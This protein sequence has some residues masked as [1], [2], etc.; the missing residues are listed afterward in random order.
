[1]Y[2]SIVRVPTTTFVLVCCLATVSIQAHLQ[3][4]ALGP[5]ATSVST[6]SDT[7]N[8]VRVTAVVTDRRG[9]PLAGLKA[10]DFELLVDGK[11]QTLDSVELNKAVTSTTRTFAFLL[12]EFHTAAED[13]GAV[14][15]G[16]LRFVEYSLRSGDLAVVVKP[17][18]T[19][20]TIAITADRDAVRRAISTFEGRKGDFTP[21]T[22][23]E[24]NY[25][26]QAPDAVASAR[27]QIVTSAL[28]AIGMM[29]SEKKTA[30]SA[31]V[32]VSDGFG[33]QRSSREVPANLL[34]AIRVANRA[35]AA[36]YAFAPSLTPPASDGTTAQIDPAFADLTAL[37]TQTGGELIT[38]RGGLDTGL[39]RINRDL[40]AHYVLA[41]RPLH[42]NDGRFHTVQVGI[43]RQGALV[44]ARSGYVAPASP[45]MR[46][47]VTPV[48]SAPLRVLRRSPLIQS[49]SGVAPGAPGRANVMVTWE[50][51]NS[52]AGAPPRS[53]PASIV[54]SASTLDG[55]MLFDAAV[56]AVGTASAP[57]LPDHASFEAPMGPVRIDMKIL[58]EKGVVIDTDSRDLM[59]PAPN[60]TG[61]TI[62]SPAILRTRSAREF[63]QDASDPD[64]PAVPTREFR[65]TERLIVRVPA[66]DASGQPIGVTA[67][68]LNRIREPMRTLPAMDTAPPG[69][70]Q[71]DLQLASLAPGDYSVRFT[72]TGPTG[73]LA[74]YVTFK[75]I[76]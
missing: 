37:T 48:S 66:I 41:Y 57:D 27:A 11:Q 55:T 56:A 38:G 21:R 5:T 26:A 75:V 71:F 35:D 25:M 40:D 22:A 49:W 54:V 1:V 46:A 58:D 59:V 13:S 23:F 62:Y 28:R 73:V 34:T 53:R 15:E 60:K 64:A 17:L 45:E 3:M 16:L 72:A 76:G 18:D 42:G 69:F 50:P 44:R 63:R 24:R 12:D 6:T 74:E 2:T 7:D 36:V 67:V 20:T 68:L 65:R 70:T 10:A 9:Q 30:L 52:R 32:L 4:Q 43:K 31:I 14:R 33:R 8:V 61:P 29:L 39:A 47:A 51:V 19:L